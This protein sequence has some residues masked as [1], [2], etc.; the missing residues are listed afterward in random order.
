MNS[1]VERRKQLLKD[2][3]FKARHLAWHLWGSGHPVHANSDFRALNRPLE[4][5]LHKKPHYIQVDSSEGVNF[6]FSPWAHIM[7]HNIRP[8]A[9]S[10]NVKVEPY[11]AEVIDE[12]LISANSDVLRNNTSVTVPRSRN[13]VDTVSKTVSLEEEVS[14][15]ASLELRQLIKYGNMASP[16]QGETE[17][18]LAISA[19]YRRA[20]Q[21]SNT[22]TSEESGGFK[23]DIPPYTEILVDR[24]VKVG[25]YRQTTRI[26]A[27]LDYSIRI[28]SHDDFQ[29]D[30]PSKAEI[31]N[32]V[33]GVG[34]VHPGDPTWAGIFLDQPFI[35]DDNDQLG[36]NM[37]EILTGP[38]RTE[39]F[40]TVEFDRAGKSE[41]VWNERKLPMPEP[42][43]IEKIVEVNKGRGNFFDVLNESM[44][45][46]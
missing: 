29:V 41:Y 46:W 12:Q 40:P 39:I 33:L 20:M 30:W 34:V 28:W 32:I 38:M 43:V 7:F 5:P 26:E 11:P 36:K 9:S 44:E 3:E 23:V 45:T 4:D 37:V 8:V 21:Q 2:L 16:V 10:D 13:F 18:K 14:V 1:V 35:R 27:D 31:R 17:F 19:A 22:E 25:K 42:E 15:S 24:M 6:E